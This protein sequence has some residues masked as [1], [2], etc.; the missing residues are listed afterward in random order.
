MGHPGNF[1]DFGIKPQKST[2]FR[3]HCNHQRMYYKIV[4]VKIQ[5]YSL[6][7]RV[8]VIRPDSHHIVNNHNL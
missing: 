8:F 3:N 4:Q 1:F 2:V 6:I 7:V 5:W